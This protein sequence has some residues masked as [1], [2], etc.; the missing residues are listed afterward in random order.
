MELDLNL[1]VRIHEL[2]KHLEGQGIQGLVETS[3]GVRS[4]MIEYDKRVLPLA[5]LLQTLLKTEQQ[6]PKA[7]FLEIELG[8]F[9][10]ISYPAHSSST[11]V[12]ITLLD[13]SVELVCNVTSGLK[14][15]GHTL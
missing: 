6:L 5:A 9:H 11:C 1:R 12:C 7:S 15:R 10:F 3:P 8:V 14:P 2:E 4:C 13:C